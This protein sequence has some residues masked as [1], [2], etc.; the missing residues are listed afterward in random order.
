[1]LESI[2]IFG[3][4]CL[5]IYFIIKRLIDKDNETFEKRDF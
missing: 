3:F 2:L 4:I 5:L 1:M